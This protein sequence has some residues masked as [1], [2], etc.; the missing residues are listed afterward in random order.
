MDRNDL[1]FDLANFCSNRDVSLQQTKHLEMRIADLMGHSYCLTM[2]SGTAA[3][4][5]AYFGVGIGFGDEVIVPTYGYFSTVTALLQVGA[6][7]I[8]VDIEMNGE[9][10][11]ERVKGAITSRTKAVV[12]IHQWGV[13]MQPSNF[14]NFAEEFGL[15]LIEDCCQ[16]LGSE[17][18]G[19]PLGS[20]G[21]VA[22]TSFN[23]SKIAGAGEGGALVTSDPTVL[24]RALI[25]GHGGSE[26]LNRIPKDDLYYQIASTGLGFKY[27]IHPAAVLLGHASLNNLE[28]TINK[29]RQLAISLF[30]ATNGLQYI[31]LPYNNRFINDIAPYEIPLLCQDTSMVCGVTAILEDIGMTIIHPVG[32]APFCNFSLFLHRYPEFTQLPMNWGCTVEISSNAIAY[33]SRLILIHPTSPLPD[34][35]LL[36][37][38]LMEYSEVTESERSEYII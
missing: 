23:N 25:L 9:F 21:L 18:N 29:R 24:K 32:N 1:I 36:H 22:V 19:R 35:A 12:I 33:K 34:I 10:A 38:R 31:S 20:F 30:E 16:A 15:I 14:A 2:N 7:P 17:Y 4:H 8:F 5:S 3:L 26:A 27:R 37:K 6:V 11:V 28:N 13:P